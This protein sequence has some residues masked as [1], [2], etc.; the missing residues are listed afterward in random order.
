MVCEVLT[1]YGPVN[2]FWFDGTKRVPDDR[3]VTDL[4]NRVYAEIRHL[5][6]RPSARTGRR[7]RHYRPVRAPARAPIQ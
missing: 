2:R 1:W 4:W 3:N 5:R 6:R 7:L